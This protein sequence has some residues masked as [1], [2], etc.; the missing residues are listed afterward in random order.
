MEH[1][2]NLNWQKPRTLKINEY[3]ILICSKNRCLKCE[4]ERSAEEKQR[5]S[6]ALK[7]FLFLSNNIVVKETRK[8]P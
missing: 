4:E 1:Q 8:S 5:N 2:L 3:S 7:I 6:I